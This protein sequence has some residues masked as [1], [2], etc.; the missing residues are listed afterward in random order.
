M[1]FTEV[2]QGMDPQE[3]ALSHVDIWVQVYD[4]PI[5]FM[6]ERVAVD[7]GCYVKVDAKNFSGSWCAYMCIP[8]SINISK[9]LKRHED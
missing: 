2:Q 7:I 8:V 3:V 5:G 9:P 4:L 6:S 1:V